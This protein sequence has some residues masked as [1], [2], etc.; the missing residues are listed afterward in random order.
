M[1]RYAAK[2]I[3]GNYESMDQMMTNAVA[4]ITRKER[5]YFILFKE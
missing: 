2:N 1:H 3:V 4:R 5:I